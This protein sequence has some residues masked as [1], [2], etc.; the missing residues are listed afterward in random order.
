MTM[1]ESKAG[2]MI[3]RITAGAQHPNIKGDKIEDLL[4][5]IDFITL[6]G[7]R[8]C[9]KGMIEN[10][11]EPNESGIRMLDNTPVCANP[12]EEEAARA[13]IEN[14]IDSF[15][16]YI[17]DIVIGHDV[18]PDEISVCFYL[19]TINL[20][21]TLTVNTIKDKIQFRPM[22]CASLEE[23]LLQEVEKKIVGSV[24]CPEVARGTPLENKWV[25]NKDF[26]ST[27]EEFKTLR[28]LKNK[29]YRLQTTIL[30]LRRLTHCFPTEDRKICLNI[31]EEELKDV[32]AA[33]AV[34]NA[35][36]N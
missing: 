2:E 9:L 29:W 17:A 22:S 14:L 27:E 11:I 12:D 16:F 25:C 34:A 10:T 30:Y 24:V 35:I 4:D 1:Q 31:F 36:I 23:Y 26:L 19:K 3:G 28:L 5:T 6:R 8:N 7:V 33:L 18:A 21:Y 15:G 20:C 32:R 13:C